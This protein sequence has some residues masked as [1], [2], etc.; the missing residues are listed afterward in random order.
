MKNFLLLI[1]GIIIFISVPIVV[2]FF[3]QQQELRKKAA[4]ATTLSIQPNVTSVPVGETVIWKILINTGEN[5]VASVKVSLL[6]DQT[7]FEAQSITNS[8][9][10]PRILNQGTVGLGTATITVAA[11]NTT[12]PITGQGEIAVLR[13]KALSPSSAPVTVQFAPDTFAAGIG[14]QTVNVLT[15]TEPGSITITGGDQSAL[16]SSSVTTTPVPTGTPL[17]PT[18]TPTTKPLESM[19]SQPATASAL[20]L[21][22]DTEATRGGKPLIHGTATPGATLTIVV[23]SVTPQ[24][25]VVTANSSGNWQTT[26]MT[27]LASGTYTVVVTALHPT[28][29]TSETL[30]SSF[31]IGGGIGG[32]EV[33]EATGEALPESGSAKT[34]LI[35][36][37]LG[38]TLIVA[39]TISFALKHYEYS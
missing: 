15:G 34:T 11:Q 5:K 7:K 24:T 26:P 12:K 17:S 19:Y 18:P 33:T 20:T 39:G 1:T 3:G 27:A 31:T 29:G 32:A 25:I 8:T 14:E 23:Y 10:A 6:F 22:I 28:A 36:L 21:S 16:S 30:S 2:F 4:P 13:L 35:L 9:L 38:S 37:I